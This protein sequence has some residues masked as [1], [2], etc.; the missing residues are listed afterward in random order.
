MTNGFH[1]SS[2][3]NYAKLF[4]A[5]SHPTRIKIVGILAEER[6]YVS[7]LAKLI[8]LSR[9][10]LYMHLRKLEDAAIVSDSYE[11]SNSGKTQ[12]YYELKRFS[13]H[14]TP[15]LLT[16]VARTIPLAGEA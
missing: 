4:D 3:E 16:E 5:L 11:I 14:L 13:I 12:K 1:P 7:E 10:L 6:R 8:N 2:Y 9:P 15:E